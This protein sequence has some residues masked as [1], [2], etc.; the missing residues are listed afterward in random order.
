MVRATHGESA[1]C[2]GLIVRKHDAHGADACPEVAPRLTAAQIRLLE[3]AAMHH[4]LALDAA[5]L[6]GDPVLARLHARGNLALRAC[7]AALVALGV[8]V[9]AAW[10]MYADR[11]PV[12]EP[13]GA[14]RTLQV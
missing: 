7:A 14:P 10:S 6:A 8:V 5:T 9:G 3:R 4:S 12:R 1:P 2:A 13:L 11:P